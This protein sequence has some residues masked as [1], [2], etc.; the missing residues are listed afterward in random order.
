MRR[1]LNLSPRPVYRR[2]ITRRPALV[3]ISIAAG[4]S[5]AACEQQPTSSIAEVKRGFAQQ[6]TAPAGAASSLGSITAASYDP[7][8]FDLVQV[9]VAMGDSFFMHAGRAELVVDAERD[10]MMIRFLDVIWTKPTNAA[11]AT[12]PA[13]NSDAAADPASAFDGRLHES[14]VRVSPAWDLGVDVL[15]N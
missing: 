1:L 10:T 12:A 6:A 5:L 9:N 4:V 14:P 8:T 15:P 3:A 11:G 7:E 2:P 13:A